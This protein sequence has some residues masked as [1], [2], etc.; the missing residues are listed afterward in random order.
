MLEMPLWVKEDLGTNGLNPRWTVP[1][2]S[3]PIFY[4]NPANGHTYTVTSEPTGIEAARA[5]AQ[6]IGGHL[7][8]I[9]NEAENVFLLNTFG[10]FF[11][12]LQA[13]AWIGL[14]DEVTEGTYLWDNGDSFNYSNW[15]IGEPNNYAGCGAGS[16]EDYNIIRLWASNPNVAGVWNDLPTV[17]V[18]Q[19][20][21]SWRGIIEVSQS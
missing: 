21:G 5:Q 15:A 13:D 12:N 8:T 19:N 1:L 11:N 14:S 16:N 9:N 2:T 3:S 4:F 20:A 17:S 6:A 7:V 10:Q 18:C